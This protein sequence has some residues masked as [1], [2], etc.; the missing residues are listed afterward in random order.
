MKYH[1]SLLLLV[2]ALSVLMILGPKILQKPLEKHSRAFSQANEKLTEEVT[3][4]FDGYNALYILG[5]KQTIK[6]QVAQ[7]SHFFAKSKIGLMTI[8]GENNGLMKVGSIITCSSLGGVIFGNLTAFSFS[9]VGV[10]S[11]KPILEKFQISTD[12]VTTPQQVTLPDFHEQLKMDRV[13]YQYPGQ[14]APTLRDFSLQIDKAR[15]YALIAPSGYGKSTIL[16]LL[17]AMYEEYQGKLSIDGVDYRQLS[18]DAIQ[19]QM[20]YVD[21]HPYI[22]AASL[23]DNIVMGRTVTPEKLTAVCEIC[24]IDQFLG[25]LSAGLETNLRHS[26]SNL[27]GGQMQRIALAR[28]LLS[29]RPILLL[30]EIT[31]ALDADTA[32]RIEQNIL[33][34]PDKTVVMV[35][36]NLRADTRPLFDE[37]VDLTKLGIAD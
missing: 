20:L 7:S 28:M 12:E 6:R 37:I 33:Q 21:Q 19:S 13:T 17:F 35:T 11:T 18:E 15:K 27:S 22:F 8:C 5:Q 23:R 3:D 4:V 2:M 32:L 25:D 30:D 29:D 36:H 10:R 24:G 16:N 34:Q 31:S 26:G 9:I 14:A 1:Y